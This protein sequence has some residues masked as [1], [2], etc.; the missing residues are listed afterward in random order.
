LKVVK[1][2]RLSVVPRFFEHGAQ[3]HLVV[4]AMAYFP[5]DAT[6]V[7]LGEQALWNDFAAEAK[8][9][10][11]TL[12]QPVS[13]AQAI[14]DEGLPK[15]RGEV[16]VRGRAFPPGGAAPGCKVR[17]TVGAPAAPMVD[18][19]LVVSGDRHWDFMGMSM[20]QPFT[21]LPIDWEHAFG[22]PSYAANPVGRGITEVPGPDGKPI[23]PLPNVEVESERVRAK[24]DRPKP[25][26][27]GP[28]DPTHPLRI[29]KFGT[30]D[31]RWLDNEFPGMPSD[32]HLEAHNCAPEDQR[33]DGWFAGGEPFA[34]ENMHATKSRLEGFLPSLRVRA[35]YTMKGDRAAE[36]HE[37]GMRLETVQLFPHRERGVLVFRGV[38]KTVEDDGHDLAALMVAGER[39]D[40]PRDLAHYRAVLAKRLDK[41][42]G[43]IAALRDID[44]LPEMPKYRGAAGPIEDFQ[45]L[46]ARD[47]L[48]E[49][50]FERRAALDHERMKREFAAVGLDPAAF[51]MPAEPQKAPVPPSLA[52]DDLAQTIADSDERDR[53]EEA[54]ADKQRQEM[55]SRGRALCE[56]HGIDYERFVKKGEGGPPKFRAV[57]ELDKLRAA[58]ARAAELGVPLPEL[59]QRANDPEFEQRLILQ[60]KQQL[61]MYRDGAHFMPSAAVIEDDRAK[62]LGARVSVAN[63]AQ[64]SLANED[65]TGADLCDAVMP[66]SDLSFTFLETARLDRADL[67][68][69]NLERSV[70]TRASLRGANLTGASLKGANLGEA[71]LT[72]ADL[73][74]VDL[75]GAVLFRATLDKTKLDG[76]TLHDTDVWE[77]EVRD[78][79]LKKA[80]LS[81]V[82][83]LRCNIDRLDAAGAKLFDVTLLECKAPK[84]D[85]SDATVEE[86][87]LISTSAPDASFRNATLVKMSALADC[88]LPGADFSGAKMPEASLRGANLAGANF[89]GAQLDEADLSECNLV[90]ANL[91]RAILTNAALIRTDLGNAKVRTSKLLGAIMHKAQLGGA[92]FAGSNLFSAD[93]TKARG[94]DR[95]SFSGTN[96]GRAVHP[97][98]RKS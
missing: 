83:F 1:P 55:E 48:M 20:P 97:R 59:Q 37:V 82:S 44:L 52:L 69:A 86:L 81:K 45:A 36:L 42:E 33:I 26:G 71:D 12:E 64:V 77:T 76:V 19:R 56:K 34:I 49:K 31:K 21:E 14:L 78:V 87:H 54:R 50:N 30:F 96:L 62:L 93:L 38:A 57:V 16:I 61:D 3:P 94:D 43:A 11:P 75:T 17:V 18:K 91:D 67:T 22:G 95:T 65:L 74:G 85:L 66:G 28:L 79:S 92:D 6:D 60:E 32:M 46:V 72:G 70:L 40:A 51:G 10:P 98:P 88:S 4:T 7:L 80:T 68:G 90:G 25:A 9:A 27:L 73:T 58:V 89:E 13:V 53:E 5:L 29:A 84:L 63:D 24:G 35:F 41:E 47:G 2:L 23:V 39:S 15:A 8:L